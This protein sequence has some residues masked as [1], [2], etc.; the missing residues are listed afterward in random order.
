VKVIENII[1]PYK[2]AETLISYSVPDHP[3]DVTLI[4]G[5]GRYNDINQP[6]LKYLSNALPEEKV[7]LVRFNYPFVENP[8]LLVMRRSCRLV[9]K[10]VLEDIK[11]ELPDSKFLFVG[12]KSLSAV[13]AAEV[14]PKNA[15]GYVFLSWPLHLPK[16]HIPFPRKMLFQLQKPMLFVNGS[17]DTYCDRGKLELMVGALNPFARLML[18][19]ES[20]HSLELLREG[21]RKQEEIYHEISEIVVWFMSDIIEN[22]KKN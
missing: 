6:L 22:M 1:Y 7:N 16:I 4:L 2:G 14:A 18:I 12:G 15:A 9:Y 5:H 3:S 20:G 17:E 10:A 19:P 13:V 21:K 11:G 8:R